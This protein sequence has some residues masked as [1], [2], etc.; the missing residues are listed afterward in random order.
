MPA[1]TDPREVAVD[2][3]SYRR[4]LSARELLPAVGVGVAAGMLAFYVTRVLMQRAPVT[5]EGLSLP[6]RGKALPRTIPGSRAS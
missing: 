1:K 3:Y 6:R 5:A 2:T 4:A